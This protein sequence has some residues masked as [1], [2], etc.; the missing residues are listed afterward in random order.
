MSNESDHTPTPDHT[1][2]ADLSNDLSVPLLVAALHN[3]G[4]LLDRLI[5]EA[6][7][8]GPEETMSTLVGIAGG[9][10]T[11]L[12]PRIGVEVGQ[13]IHAVAKARLAV[14]DDT[15]TPSR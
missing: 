10:A 13:L 2:G 12:A 11:Q 4:P 6:L 14:I 1:P 8:D 5:D 3:D 7:R 15:T 9:L